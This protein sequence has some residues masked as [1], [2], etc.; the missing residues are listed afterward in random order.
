MIS[1]LMMMAQEDVDRGD[2]GEGYVDKGGC[3]VRGV[4]KVYG[5]GEHRDRL[6]YRH[7]WNS[8]LPR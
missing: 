8:R 3:V 1:L 4:D 2:C 6:T 5:C 7:P